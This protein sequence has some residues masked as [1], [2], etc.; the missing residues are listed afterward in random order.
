MFMQCTNIVLIKAVILAIKYSMLVFWFIFFVGTYNYEL[1]VTY[2]LSHF[3]F[4]LA[5]SLFPSCRL[6]C[7][8]GSRLNTTL[9]IEF[10]VLIFGRQWLQFNRP[11]VC[12]CIL[13]FHSLFFNIIIVVTINL[14]NFQVY[15]HIKVYPTCIFIIEDK[16]KMGYHIMKLRIIQNQDDNQPW[17]NAV[18]LGSKWSKCVHSANNSWAE[19]H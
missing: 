4:R 2:R 11:G 19:N 6:P 9:H 18:C 13:A 17:S 8:K 15:D 12:T 14:L 10:L 7:N 3:S 16:Q 5:M 1:Y